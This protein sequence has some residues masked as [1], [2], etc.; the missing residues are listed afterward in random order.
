M[1]SHTDNQIRRRGDA[2]NKVFYRSDTR[3]LRLNDQYFFASREGDQGPFNSEIE[4]HRELQRHIAAHNELQNF[5]LKRELWGLEQKN[6][7]ARQ[8]QGD[9]LFTLEILAD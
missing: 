4:A 3:I 2:G 6:K 7:E 1:S 5:Q 8:A 9:G